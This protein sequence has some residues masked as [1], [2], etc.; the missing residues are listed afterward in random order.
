MWRLLWVLGGVC[1]GLVL[2]GGCSAG[3][4]GSM[5]YDPQNPNANPNL[6]SLPSQFAS[7]QGTL[8]WSYYAAAAGVNT[9]TPLAWGTAPS[10]APAA[11]TACWQ[12]AAA[13][14]VLIAG[15][16]LTPGTGQ[17]AVIGWRV[18]RT[19]MAQVSLTI[20]SKTVNAQSNGIAAG[21]WLDDTT[22]LPLTGVPANGQSQTLTVVHNIEPLHTLYFR[23]SANGSA[24][25]DW[26]SYQ[27]SITLQ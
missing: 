19:G 21:I 5:N 10:G 1:A 8:G 2:W 18:S 27:I 3:R 15:D 24:A 13:P 23:F 7:T 4:G 16:R 12:N 9:Y 20:Q 6:F 11:V 22:L 26:F 25:Y 14:G 17:D